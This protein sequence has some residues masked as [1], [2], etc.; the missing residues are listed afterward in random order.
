L[1]ASNSSTSS[2][3]RWIQAK[4]VIDLQVS[5]NDLESATLTFHGPLSA[6]GFEQSPYQ[7]D[8]IP[9]GIDD[10]RVNWEKR[11]WSRHD[12]TASHVNLHVRKAGSPNERLALLFR[13]WFRAHPAAIPAY[14]AFKQSVAAI[15]NNTGAYAEVKDPVVD[16]VNVVAEA[17]AASVNW[18]V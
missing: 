4:D 3:A 15:T 11:L 8:H 13:D 9:A 17:W 7:A 18:K 10:D 2:P 12:A 6:L 16:L 14:G 5:V 1:S